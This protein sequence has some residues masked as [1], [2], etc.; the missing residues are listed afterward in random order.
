[1]VH[2]NAPDFCAKKLKVYK[3]F[4][5]KKKMPQLRTILDKQTNLFTTHLFKHFK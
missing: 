1:M 2:K 3:K 4:L 5:K